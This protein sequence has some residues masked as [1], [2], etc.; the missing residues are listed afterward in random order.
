[1]K[2]GTSNTGWQL[3]P[4]QIAALRAV[5]ESWKTKQRTLVVAATGTGK[6]TIFAEIAKRRRDAGRG[7]TL[8]LAH[9]TELLTQAS[10]RMRTAGLTTELDCGDS[11]ASTHG[12][13][14]SDVV[15]A[16]V[17]TLRGKRLKRWT[18][19]AF[20]TVIVDEA[21]HAMAAGYRAVLDH[22]TPHAK[23]LGV[24]ATPDRG[25]GVALAGVI[26][27]LAY[28][29]TLR[30]GIRDGYLCPLRFM[31][32]NTP[33]ID[34]SSVRTTS[35][36]GVRDFSAEDLA[37]Q[38]TAEKSLHEMAAPIVQE[39]GDRPTIVF[40]PTVEV[41]H[42]L[43]TVMAAYMGRPHAVA[44]LDGTSHRDVRA[45]TLERFKGGKIQ[46]L[47]N[48]ALF[49]E[50]FDAPTTSCVAIARMTKSRALYAQM[51]GRGTRLAP[52]KDYCL[53]LDLAPDN[54]RHELVSPT[55]LFAGK[56]GDDAEIA[57]DLSFSGGANMSS[58]EIEKVLAEAE[59]RAQQQE[60]ARARDRRT[61]NVV[62]DVKYHRFTRDPFAIIGEPAPGVVAH[63]KPPSAK[64]IAALEKLGVSPAEQPLDAT[65]ANAL[66]GALKKRKHEGICT[67]KQAR[68]LA[69]RGLDPNL[70]FNE[71]SEA[72]TLLAGNGW[73]MTPEIAERFGAKDD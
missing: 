68:Q 65:S 54:A 50:G 7:R 18:P 26:D 49:T 71:A 10:D 22:F 9:R 24:T 35:L 37:R 2:D 6:T 63:A 56:F 20:G 70:K 27:D 8:V 59:K 21:H 32:I 55:D 1:M 62:A 5:S 16:T 17:Q 57:D 15:I 36:S 69:Q 58:E 60:A 13:I 48:C 34:M 23:I 12:L 67:F 61:S 4:Y 40:T 19:D 39:M 72:M 51:V 47:V 3:R 31:S 53:V 38:M 44:S 73:K 25:D 28:E 14:V 66:F 29:Y 46:V 43:G 30:D 64:M 45:D 11:V 41:A 42:A 52:G 33:S